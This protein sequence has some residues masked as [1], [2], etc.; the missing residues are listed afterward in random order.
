MLLYNSSI[1]EFILD[2][3]RNKIKLIAAVITAKIINKIP[4]IK[5]FSPSIS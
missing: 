3:A 1:D 2:N 5:K 4:T